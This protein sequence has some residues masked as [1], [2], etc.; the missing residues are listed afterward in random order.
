MRLD[1]GH[2]SIYSGLKNILTGYLTSPTF[3]LRVPV[4]KSVDNVVI[5]LTLQFES[6]HVIFNTFAPEFIEL[7]AVDCPWRFVSVEWVVFINRE[8]K[9]G[10]ELTNCEFESI[11]DPFLIDVKDL[12]KRGRVIA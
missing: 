5:R 7:S 3:L 12:V 4:L 6:E 1:R 2:V 10:I 9:R 11:E 8:I